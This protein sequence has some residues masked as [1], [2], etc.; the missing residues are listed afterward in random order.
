MSGLIVASVTIASV[1][2]E[3]VIDTGASASFLPREG[4]VIKQSQIDLL[5]TKTDTRIADNN[6]L[7]CTRQTL[8]KVLIWAGSLRR[9]DA[10]FLVINKSSHILGYDALFGT[11]LIKAFN[12]TISNENNCLIAKIESYPI[13]QEDTVE[14][15]QQH[16]AIVTRLKKATSE[17]SPLDNLLKRYSV[18]SETAEEAMDTSP[19]R[20][21]IDEQKALLMQ[22][23]KL[24]RY[25]VEDIAE[26]DRQVKSMLEKGIIEPS[27]SRFSSTCH[28]VPK[29][30]GQSRLVINYI[31]LNRITI[32]DH[33]PLPQITDLLAHLSKARY[34]CALDCTEG[35]WQIPV[36]P[37]D[38]YK[39]AFVTPQGLFQFKRCPFGFT[40]SP[41]VY[42]RA[43]NEIFKEGIYRRCVIYIDDILVFG[44]TEEETLCNLEWVLRMCEKHK[45]KLKMSKCE[46]LKTEVN[47]LG[48]KVGQ[49]TVKPLTRK[50]NL[51]DRKEP[52]TVK[53]A[54]GFLGYINYYAR[55]IENYSEKA[56]VI[57][58]SINSQPFN[59]SDECRLTKQTL[60]E[61]LES[62]TEQIIPSTTTPKQ[63][64]LAVFD[65]SIEAACL[66]EEGNLIM[67]TSAI[68]SSTEKNYS[69]LERE[70]LALKRAYKNFGPFLRGPVVVKSS[71]NAL[72]KALKLKNKPERVAR[73]LLELPPEAEFK[74]EVY[75]D[76]AE[77]IQ[78][79]EDPP[80][81][82]FYTDGACKVAQDQKG[83]ASWA[84][85]SVNR[86]ELNCS[87]LLTESSNQKAE[88]EAVIRACMIAKSHDL[89]RILIATDS[90]YVYN[91]VEKWID[92]WLGNNWLDNKNKPVKNEDAFKRLLVAKE[93][94]DLK[95]VHV[96]GHKGDKY[97]ELADKL[98]RE[99]LLS[100]IV[101]CAAISAPPILGQEEDEE[102]KKIKQKIVDGEQIADYCLKDGVLHFSR[103]GFNKLVVPHKQRQLL[104][105]LSHSDPI[106]GAHYGVKKTNLKLEHYHWPGMSS[107]IKRFIASCD[108]CQKNKDSKQKAYGKL[109]P[110]KTS[111]LFNR[112]H[113]DL[114]GPLTE[115]T[116]GNKYI[117]TAIDAYSRLGLA[118]P[119]K[120][121][122]AAEVIQ[123][124][125][126]E[127]ITKHGPPEHLVSD[128]GT[129][130]TSN[131][132]KELM[133]T[134]GIKHS[135]T[136]EYNPKANGMDEK[137]NGTLVK[138]IKNCID[139]DKRQWDTLLSSAIL[140]YNIT[141]NA[142]TKLSPYTLVYGRLPRSP[143]NP[144]EME[145]DPST[146]DHDNIR[147]TALDN[148]DISQEKMADQYNK[149]RKEF[150]FEPMDLVMAKTLFVGRTESR[151]WAPK[152]TGPHC[153]L[154]ILQHSGE[155]KALEILDSD[156]FKVRRLSF[157]A[158]KEYFPPKQTVDA[159]LPGQVLCKLLQKVPGFQPVGRSNPAIPINGLIYSPDRQ[160]SSSRSRPC[161]CPIDHGGVN[162]SGQGGPSP[163]QI[164][165]RA[166]QNG[167]PDHAVDCR[168]LDYEGV[169]PSNR[170][171]PS[172]LQITLRT[173][174]NDEPDRAVDCGP[175]DHGGVNPSD[176]A[177]PSS[178]QIPLRAD[179][180]PDHVV[181]SREA[182]ECAAGIGPSDHTEF[183][184][185]NQKSIN[186]NV[187]PLHSNISE[188]SPQ[189]PT[190]STLTCNSQDVTTEQPV[191]PGITATEGMGSQCP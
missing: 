56:K 122:N 55:F 120:S 30:T 27:V 137:F 80:E 79:M 57:Q 128:N 142:S 112:I 9:H 159:T 150:R 127:I 13:G 177:G 72:P 39:T 101:S 135:T 109:M 148:M 139:H 183:H 53:E 164:P 20:I 138:I 155:D 151:K 3:V 96:R 175:P 171:G 186:T 31:P 86:P 84:V 90:K 18:F 157:S 11:D 50:N 167:G 168:S 69:R 119:C 29:K 33:Y 124:L 136:C 179:G 28:L 113:M 189:A 173:D 89:K 40:N 166:D 7:D 158:V 134:L 64:E 153:I 131:S 130:F 145:E 85:I 160:I 152:W 165:Q 154:R 117:V 125:M 58:R 63:V 46:F 2:A 147:Q 22:K 169:N 82:T 15:Y 174:Q 185:A 62:A 181:N 98:A 16:L 25:S 36:E 43:M 121:A 149:K 141:P 170:E 129:Q 95:I 88:I 19:M 176:R 180:G 61:D 66:S 116:S 68:L 110:I 8:A 10:R 123:L 74:V 190:P 143:L 178:L 133:Q 93:G 54:Q 41:A 60:L 108:V 114:I 17:S 12:I 5:K 126:D 81:E 132:F 83:L 100:N 92:R 103:A 6:Q 162:L 102:I 106:F 156:T 42:Q 105:Q 35:F 38:R 187:S 97:N 111:N 51:W 107:D 26:I 182:S 87:G 47:F 24:R 115:S 37:S 91:A 65:D 104:L 78:R 172:P 59:W 52:A 21:E 77:V 1:V 75:N 73:I 191:E 14:Q 4:L 23:A 144:S 44:S 48:Y 49:G 71:C 34:F 118:R 45:V 140:A 146:V 94:I 76:V 32:K 161:C 67:R 163:L 184:A 188:L 99:T 70:L